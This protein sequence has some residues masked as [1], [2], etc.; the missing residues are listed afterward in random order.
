M[1]SRA[2]IKAA[3]A[4]IEKIETARDTLSTGDEQRATRDNLQKE[5]TQLFGGLQNHSLTS[6]E[7]LRD[8]AL[9]NGYSVDPRIL[10]RIEIEVRR[11]WS[12]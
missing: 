1:E 8:V 2:F 12:V 11:C 6:A 5:V 10:Q 7:K 9:R 4:L 3:A